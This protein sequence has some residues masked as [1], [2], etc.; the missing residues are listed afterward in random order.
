M[1]GLPARDR[2]SEGLGRITYLTVDQVNRLVECAKA[3][4]NPQIYP[5]I[6]IGLE[7]RCARARFFR[8][9]GKT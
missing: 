4:G 5:F 8:S 6:V 2:F 3:D 1:E 9:A 7:P